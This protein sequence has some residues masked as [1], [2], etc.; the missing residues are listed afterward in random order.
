MSFERN[1][2]HLDNRMPKSVN[3]IIEVPPS[4]RTLALRC[5]RISRE[6]TDP[7]IADEIEGIGAELAHHALVLEW[8]LALKT[9]DKKI[10]PSD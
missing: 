9:K 5:S 7:Q 6:C 2:L 1:Y 8:F 10:G 3:D 4:L